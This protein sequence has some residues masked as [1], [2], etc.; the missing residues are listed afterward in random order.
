VDWAVGGALY[1]NAKASSLQALSLPNT[2]LGGICLEH[3]IND[4]IAGLTGWGARWTAIESQLRADLGGTTVP[5]Y[6]ARNHNA[7]P[8]Y[9]TTPAN[10]PIHL[11]EQDAWASSNRFPVQKPEGPWVDGQVHLATAAQNILGE[12]YLAAWLAHPGRTA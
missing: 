4:A 10:W 8:S 12:R 7:M 1:T 9:V 2:I 3:G 5:L 6:Y 11:A